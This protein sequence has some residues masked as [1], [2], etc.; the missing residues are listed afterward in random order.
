METMGVRLPG[1]AVP[2]ATVK[3]SAA[4]SLNSLMVLSSINERIRHDEK[5][6]S[7]IAAKGR[8]GRFDLCVAMNICLRAE[9]P[10]CWLPDMDRASKVLQITKRLI[11]FGNDGF[12]FRKCNL[13]LW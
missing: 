7:R 13:T 8:H 1:T 11:L 6:A 5:A 9:A 3:S 2:V 10:R 4:I 12:N